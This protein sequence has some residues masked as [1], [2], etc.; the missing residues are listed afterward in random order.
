MRQLQGNFICADFDDTGVIN[1]NDL[2]MLLGMF[3]GIVADVPAA[4]E[5]DLVRHAPDR[6]A[7]SR[8]HTARAAPFSPS[9]PPA[10]PTAT[11]QPVVLSLALVHSS[12]ATAASI[13][14]PRIGSGGSGGGG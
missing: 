1:V 7:R 2:L 10:R 6:A 5:F 12:S 8:P 3:G 4:G 14:R 13:D 9:S 11:R